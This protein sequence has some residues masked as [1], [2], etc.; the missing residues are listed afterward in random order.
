MANLLST[1]IT[2]TLTTTSNVGI[3]TTN[4]GERLHVVGPSN[5]WAAHFVSGTSESYFSYSAGYGAY[6][7]AGASASSS[8]YILELIS[9][10]ST[11]MFVRGDGNVGIGTTAP[12]EKLE[13]NGN[14]QI[15]TSVDA[16]LYMVSSGGNGYNERFFIEGYADGGTYG[17]G[18]KLSTRN[19]SNIFNTAVTVDR[20]GNV[21]FGTTSP[22][23][24]LN[25]NNGD[26]WINVTDTLRGLQFGYA[27]PSHGSYRAA[28]MGGA[29]SYGGTDSGMLTF[30][31]QSGYVVSAIPPER[32]RITSG[33]NVGI[34]TTNPGDKLE[35]DGGT[36]VIPNGQFYRGRYN[37]GTPQNL[38]GISTGNVIQVGDFSSS[39]NLQLGGTSAI[40]FMLQG[41]ERMRITSGGNVG[42]GTTSP[43]YPLHVANSGI[44]HIT[45]QQT[46]TNTADTDAYA[47]FYVINDAGTSQ[48]RGYLGAGG[49]SVGNT[50]MRDHVYVGAQT[51]HGLRLFTNDLARVTVNPSGNVGI[52][53]TSP[54]SRLD[55][56]PPASQSTISTL[57]YSA[58]AQLNIRIPNSVGDVG[59]IVFTN[60]A[61]PTAGYASWTWRY[62]LCHEINRW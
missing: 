8:T 2:G 16:K 53:T 62:G 12:S 36:V 34:G 26:A 41:T 3:G 57:G 31:T 54:Q 21:G 59:Q 47:T 56:S 46:K 19:D 52:G 44:Y 11:R 35:I 33:G 6:I 60:D 14:V 49:A 29:E 39:W 23:S 43:S 24:K 13:V 25:I 7:N 50:T 30:H 51:N 22:V 48:V 45:A 1:A 28:V 20:N 9:N 42:I 10:G 55:L 58:N 32:M 15:G 5:N 61:G 38:I 4:P 37:G 27:G 17:G 18:F 40:Q